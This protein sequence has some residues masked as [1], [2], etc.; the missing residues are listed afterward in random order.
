MEINV[1]IVC[2]RNYYL[3]LF[4]DLDSTHMETTKEQDY[5][6]DKNEYAYTKEKILSLLYE[7]EVYNNEDEEIYNVSK[8]FDLISDSYTITKVKDSDV[9]MEDVIFLTCIVDAIRDSEE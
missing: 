6:K 5:D 4:N 7:F 2:I 8:N 1:L 9:N 3:D